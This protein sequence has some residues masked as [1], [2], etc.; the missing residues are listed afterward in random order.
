M[1]PN[2]YSSYKRPH[3]FHFISAT[4]TAGSKLT[5]QHSRCTIVPCCVNKAYGTP[6][7]ADHFC[8]LLLKEQCRTN[9]DPISTDVVA[10]AFQKVMSVAVGVASFALP[11][12][13]ETSH[14]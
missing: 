11:T 12:P 6:Q 2:F 9:D 1:C 4:Q 3:L 8:I 7:A 13:E 10:K 5:A 14:M